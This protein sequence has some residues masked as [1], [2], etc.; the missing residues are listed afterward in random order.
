MLLS[1]FSM[2]SVETA[3]SSIWAVGPPKKS[4]VIPNPIRNKII[5]VAIPKNN[6]LYDWGLA[7]S[8]FLSIERIPVSFFA[9]F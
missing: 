5:T 4:R 2:L 9:F 8:S 6:D 3:S 1:A 7:R